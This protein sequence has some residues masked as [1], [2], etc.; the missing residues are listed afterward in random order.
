M[1]KLI[2]VIGIGLGVYTLIT[3]NV[4]A[5]VDVVLNPNEVT[6][7]ISFDN[8]PITHI[9]MGADSG[10]YIA[11]SATVIEPAETQAGYSI[12]IN[13]EQSSS[14][15]YF[16]R[17]S[18]TID[19]TRISFPKTEVTVEDGISEVVDFAHFDSATLLPEIIT[20]DDIEISWVTYTIYTQSQ[21]NISKTTYANI[22]T[23]SLP[24]VANTLFNV[25]VRVAATNGKTYTFSR[26]SLT[27]NSDENKVEQFVVE[28]GE[29]GTIQGNISL[30]GPFDLYSAY[31]KV[32]SV[33]GG[34]HFN[35]TKASAPTT[36]IDYTIDEV[37]ASPD[38]NEDYRLSGYAYL[39]TSTG[40]ATMQFP[41][42]AFIQPHTFSLAPD[43]T[44]TIDI[45]SEIGSVFGTINLGDNVSKEKL[46]KGSVYST[47]NR[48]YTNR[49]INLTTL[50]YE[51]PLFTVED[52]K[53][54][55]LTFT[56]KEDSAAQDTSDFAYQFLGTET[57]S[58]EPE[59][60]INQDIDLPLGSVTVNFNVVGGQTLSQ[61]RIYLTPYSM[62]CDHLNE[63][64][65]KIGRWSILGQ[66]KT[67]VDV[68]TG[69]VVLYGV[70]GI[71]RGLKALATVGNSE[72]SF[73]EIDIE[74]QAG[75]DVE[76]DINGPRLTVDVE[77][78]SV[79]DTDTITVTGTATDDTGVAG[80]TV[81]GLIAAITST[82]N[83]EDEFEVSFSVEV[84]L[85]EGINVLE[86]IAT[87]ISDKTSS[88]KRSVN[89]E[90]TQDNDGPT[91]VL[92][93]YHRQ[94]VFDSQLTVT[95]TATDDSGVES[96]TVNGLAAQLS[97]SHNPDD[98]HEV[99]FSVEIALQSPSSNP[100]VTLAKDIHDNES[101]TTLNVFLTPPST[102]KRCD[103]N[104]DNVID[105][106]DIR[107][108]FSARN[109]KVDF[110]DPRD[111]NDDRIVNVSD[112]RGCQ[113]KCDLPRCATPQ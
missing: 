111:F 56:F 45:F 41:D 57:Q 102:Y 83:P 25:H 6:G 4:F 13:V 7:T 31:T 87:D 92:D 94:E 50:E 28:K 103:A 44:K 66:S 101:T 37:P 48:A 91:I 96:I 76:I 113:L 32:Y 26:N 63:Q 40:Y 19:S 95:G 75:V 47:A 43:E 16:F 55:F 79:V 24:I 86:T 23:T 112:A 60:A 106:L 73:G 80:V 1:N 14:R 89:R 71:C 105:I 72:T 54:N 93:L 2:K 12:V 21:F 27:A 107:A 22:S 64:N 81:N 5:D 98:P 58:I 99:K 67:Q 51:L 34:T 90:I 8:R 42:G 15:A 33:G 18:I 36:S 49:V 20:P 10:E 17:P 68:E 46:M 3:A 85:V 108:I 70:D 59:E 30:P 78:N 104:A 65:E 52:W 9:Y 100:L 53:I 61:P 39:Q 82:G 38:E 109:S 29:L 110:Y 77:P 11:N 62:P 84:P 88:D 74:F 35:N 69:S 97:S